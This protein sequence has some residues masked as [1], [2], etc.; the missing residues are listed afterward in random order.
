MIILLSI[1]LTISFILNLIMLKAIFVLV[2]ECNETDK[3]LRR[4]LRESLQEIERLC[5]NIDKL[6]F[7]KESLKKQL[8]ESDINNIAS[9]IN[10]KEIKDA[11][12]F[13]ML[14]AHPDNP[15]GTHEKF[16]RYKQLYD[17]L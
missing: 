9:N 11:L 2:Q 7:E 17:K 10:R 8:Y 1:L 4:A 16:I 6:K 5:S 14:Q 3:K 12:R 15:N 13:A